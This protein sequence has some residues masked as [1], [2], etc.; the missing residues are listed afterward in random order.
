M[1]SPD[2]FTVVR[3][4][5]KSLGLS[6]DAIEDI[7]ERIREFLVDAVPNPLDMMQYPYVIRSDFQPMA[8]QNFYLALKS[9]LP[10]Q[11]VIF[12]KVSLADIFAAQP[13]DPSKTRAYTSRLSRKRVDFLLSDTMTARP[14]A[15]IQMEEQ[16]LLTRR[17]E[18]LTNAFLAAKLPLVWIYKKPSY[19][20]SE[21]KVL[22]QPYLQTAQPPAPTPPPATAPGTPYAKM[23]LRCPR[24]GS[25]MVLRT[26]ISGENQ[27]DQFWGCTRYPQCKGRLKYEPG[28]DI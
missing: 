20:A 3:T 27:V 5:L 24:C 22:F 16:N 4:F 25:E 15:G 23:P 6:T 11:L 8:E 9:I 2:K 19:S 14:V 21:L 10:E 17:D 18:F 12:P 13:S 26:A 7:T 1:Q 28:M